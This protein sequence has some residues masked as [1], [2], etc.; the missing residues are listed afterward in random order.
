MGDG[1]EGP[2]GTGTHRQAPFGFSSPFCEYGFPGLT[3][4]NTATGDSWEETKNG[5]VVHY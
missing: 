4:A 3:R 2:P 5:Q 1:A